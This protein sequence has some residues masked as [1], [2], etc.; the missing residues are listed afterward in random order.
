MEHNE[1]RRSFLRGL[2]VSTPTLAFATGSTS[3]GLPSATDAYA[4][5]PNAQAYEPVFFSREEWAF[6]VAAC[7]VIIPEDEFG[8]SLGG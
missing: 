8:P 6:V 3:A 5:P 2:L 1:N 4:A 7:D